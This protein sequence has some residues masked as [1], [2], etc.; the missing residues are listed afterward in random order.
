VKIN[1]VNAPLFRS[2]KDLQDERVKKVFFDKIT[3]QITTGLEQQ[4]KAGTVTAAP[5][6]ATAT[7]TA[8]TATPTDPF[9]AKRAR[10][11]AAAR[12]NMASNPAPIA[13]PTA[14][15][16]PENKF[17]QSVNAIFE[18]IINIDEA[19]PATN[20]PIHISDYIEQAFVHFMNNPV[21]KT[22]PILMQKVKEYAK[23]VEDTY[24]SDKG[25]IAIQELVDFGYNTLYD[26]KNPKNGT[27]NTSNTA[28]TGNTQNAGTS[29]FA[30]AISI[31]D[32]LNPK[33]KKKI[34]S[35]INNEINPAATAPNNEKVSIGG[36]EIK[37]G[38][39]LYDKIKGNL[40]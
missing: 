6:A 38:D 32:Q 16:T 26:L 34:L 17:Y 2:E 40:D 20:A 1:E 12:A 15:V 13:K 22:D 8:A 37:P 21:F 18:S 36:Q 33:Q 24:A 14:Q 30:Q 31:I 7:P 10:A 3:S 23:K 19:Q 9:A 35:Y 39:P 29:K 4:L 11:A 28:N 5:Q 25:K 27:R